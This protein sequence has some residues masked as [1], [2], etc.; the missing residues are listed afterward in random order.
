[1]IA[2]GVDFAVHAMRR[3][4]EEKTLGYAP[5]RAL[6]IGFAGVLGALGL[7][8][9]SDGIAFLSNVSSDI[10]AIIHFGI[11]AGI[12]VASSFLVLG[13]MVPLAAM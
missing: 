13:I 7:A 6:Q 2:L 11:A 4:Q 12:A 8:M 9:L 3:Y 1:M 5:R 10:Q